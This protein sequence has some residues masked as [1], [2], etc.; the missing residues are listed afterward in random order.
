MGIGR[1]PTRLW[2]KTEGSSVTNNIQYSDRQIPKATPEIGTD[3]RENQYNALTFA[4]DL[5]F[6]A[7]T[8]NGLQLTIDTAADFLKQ[9]GLN[10]VAASRC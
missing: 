10:I 1:V 8:L 6:V 2:G 7:S 9:C 4:D 5:I 3:I